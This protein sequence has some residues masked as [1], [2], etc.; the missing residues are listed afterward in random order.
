ME[1]TDFNA[2]I[3][4]ISK[5][6]NCFSFRFINGRKKSAKNKKKKKIKLGVFFQ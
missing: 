2:E 5:R 1:S 6:G 3:R 4:D